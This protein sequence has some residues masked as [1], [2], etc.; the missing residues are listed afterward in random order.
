MINKFLFKKCQLLKNEESAQR[1]KVLSSASFSAKAVTSTYD[2]DLGWIV[3]F[4]RISQEE[5]DSTL[6]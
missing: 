4:T 5:G 2:E 3:E 1:F 6:L